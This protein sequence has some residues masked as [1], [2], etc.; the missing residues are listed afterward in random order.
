MFYKT[1]FEET[2]KQKKQKYDIIVLFAEK[3]KT[4]FIKHHN[5]E[6]NVLNLTFH[7]M[8][9]LTDFQ[10]IEAIVN[11]LEHGSNSLVLGMRVNLSEAMSV[12]YRSDL[13]LQFK[14]DP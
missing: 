10:R 8:I 5:Y 11:G 9:V 3:F 1:K 4:A 2:L 12:E 13:D 7:D 14:M 6:P